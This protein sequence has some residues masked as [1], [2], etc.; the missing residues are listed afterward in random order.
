MNVHAST[1]RRSLL[2]A[3]LSLR[4]GIAGAAVGLLWLVVL[5]ALS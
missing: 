5:W 1:P 3:G 4:L 2:G